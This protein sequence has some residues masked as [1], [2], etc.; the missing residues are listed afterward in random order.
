M[1]LEAVEVLVAFPAG[2]AAVRLVLFHAHGARIRVKGLGIDDGEGA[3]VVV[4]EG[5][6]IVAVLQLSV[7]VNVGSG[8][9][10][11]TLLW[12]FNPFWF[13]YAFSHP[14]TGQ[15]KGLGR[16]PS[17]GGSGTPANFCCSLI[18]FASSLFSL[19]C[20]SPS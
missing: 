5:L 12:Y 3:V 7:E 9:G 2:V 15:W 10:T 16:P 14:I 4:F 18:V 11:L 6:G 20:P 13:L 17:V 1:V 19:Y 8:H